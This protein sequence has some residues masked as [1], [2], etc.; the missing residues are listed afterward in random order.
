MFQAIKNLKRHSMKIVCFGF[1][2]VLFTG[3]A[4]ANPVA[5]PVAPS[6]A[7]P[8]TSTL[9]ALL[10]SE[11]NEVHLTKMGDASIVTVKGRAWMWNHV[12]SFRLNDSSTKQCLN[13]FVEQLNNKTVQ[14]QFG[15]YY[16]T[17]NVDQANKLTVTEITVITECYFR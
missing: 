12:V 9:M 3:S 11:V 13:N 6:G 8:L 2:L 15:G 17:Q 1:A 10:F 16:A 14:L 5:T 4:N 7:T